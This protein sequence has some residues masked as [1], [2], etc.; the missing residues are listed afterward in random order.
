MAI[1]RN[2]SLEGLLSSFETPQIFDSLTLISGFNVDRHDANISKLSYKK[3]K[4]I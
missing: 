1:E 2:R 4:K 3:V